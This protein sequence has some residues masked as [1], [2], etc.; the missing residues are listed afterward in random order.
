V[1]YAPFAFSTTTDHR[2][3]FLEFQCDKLFGKIPLDLQPLSTRGVK[4]K[5]TTMVVRFVNATYQK[6]QRHQAFTYQ[7]EIDNDTASPHAEVKTR[8]KKNADDV[9]RNF[10]PEPLFNNALQ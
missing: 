8:Q 2:S 10:T 1:G 5:D 6:L 3:M 9:T 7:D 4:T